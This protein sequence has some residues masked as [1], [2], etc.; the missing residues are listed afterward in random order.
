MNSKFIFLILFSFLLSEILSI[1]TISKY[2]TVDVKCSDD[3]VIFDSSGFNLNEDMYF[4]FS[5]ST[6][7]TSKLESK[8]KY[9]FHSFVDDSNADILSCSRKSTSSTS[10]SSKSGYTKT[11][12]TYYTINKD[13]DEK[14]LLIEFYCSSGTLTIENTEENKGKQAII[15]IVVVVVVCAVIAII[16][17]VCTCIR[18]RQRQMAKASMQTAKTGMIMQAAAN[19]ANYYAQPVMGMG[20]TSGYGSGYAMNNMPPPPGNMGMQQPI[21][22]SR[23]GDDVTQIEPKSPGQYVPQSSGQRIK[24]SKH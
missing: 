4:T 20:M 6:T 21:A 5:L 19:A 22:Y 24:K 23:V 1:E 15:I 14:Y 3:R 10:T 12:K 18:R 17:I 13:K 9:D 16:V 11:Y 8:I 2:G 7:S